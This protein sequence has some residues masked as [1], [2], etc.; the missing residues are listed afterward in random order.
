MCKWQDLNHL[1][2]DTKTRGQ[3]AKPMVLERLAAVFQVR[4]RRY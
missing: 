4:I 1:R 2:H 3:K